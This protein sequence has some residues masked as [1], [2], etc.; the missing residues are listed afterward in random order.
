MRA[1]AGPCEATAAMNSSAAFAYNAAQTG[2]LGKKKKTASHRKHT[3]LS[4]CT[5]WYQLSMQPALWLLA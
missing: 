3:C 5:Q 1:A 2:S 4:E